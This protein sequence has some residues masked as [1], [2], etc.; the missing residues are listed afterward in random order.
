MADDLGTRMSLIEERVD[1][2]ET[3]V[4]KMSTKLDGVATKAD[5]SALSASIE[6]RDNQYNDKMW[7]LVFG[8]TGIVAIL[9]GVT[10]IA[11]LFFPS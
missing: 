10:Q 6:K 7:K 4:S 2:L 8:L 9:A 1:R 5:L 3:E 11:K